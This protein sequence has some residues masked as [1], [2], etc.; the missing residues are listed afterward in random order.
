M[1]T[2]RKIPENLSA[3]FNEEEKKRWERILRRLSEMPAFERVL[4][5]V[6]G[7]TTKLMDDDLEALVSEFEPLLDSFVPLPF[8]ARILN[9]NI[10]SDLIGRY[11]LDI[12]GIDPD[13]F[14]RAGSQ[15]QE[16]I[17]SGQ[18]WLALP[19]E[20]FRETDF[21]R[22][23]TLLGATVLHLPKLFNQML[24]VLGQHMSAILRGASEDEKF[25]KILFR[26]GLLDINDDNTFTVHFDRFIIALGDPT[27]IEE[28]LEFMLQYV[29]MEVFHGPQSIMGIALSRSIANGLLAAADAVRHSG[30]QEQF[31]GAVKDIGK[32][33]EQVHKEVTSL[34]PD[35]DIVTS[36]L[37][38]IFE[39]IS[40][41]VGG[42]KREFAPMYR[43][44][45]EADRVGVYPDII[46][47]AAGLA[48]KIF[49]ASEWEWLER[50]QEASIRVASH[51]KPLYR[52]PIY[53][54]T[55]TC[56]R[57]ASVG[58]ETAKKIVELASRFAAGKVIGRE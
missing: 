39:R 53:W 47:E 46:L 9:P 40:T 13:E 3:F 35:W 28:S 14:Y 11:I 16:A 52:Q 26:H 49:T 36:N 42:V 37:R 27:F 19:K 29:P 58:E 30:R 23:V 48:T 24:G 41:F 57:L 33:L 31:V 32:K 34:Q 38:S 7:R 17:K 55:L 12:T 4:S 45:S 54:L 44:S 43:I 8:G 18:T 2:T 51:T 22:V 15:V 25:A 21:E 5:Y 1:M 6:A 20:I 56:L 50:T 10:V